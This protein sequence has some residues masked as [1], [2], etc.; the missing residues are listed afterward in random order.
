MARYDK[1]GDGRPGGGNGKDWGKGATQGSTEGD[2]L[3]G[4]HDVG[5]EIDG[6]EG[7]DNINGFSGNDIL[8]GGDGADDITTG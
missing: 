5:D 2:H 7:D 3:Q 8:T 1:S 6:L 4:Q